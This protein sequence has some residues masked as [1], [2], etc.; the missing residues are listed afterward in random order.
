MSRL[1]AVYPEFGIQEFDD[2]AD[3]DRFSEDRESSAFGGADKRRVLKAC[4]HC[5]RHG[6]RAPMQR[7]GQF[8]PVAV[9]HDEVDDG[10]VKRLHIHEFERAI[11]GIRRLDGKAVSRKGACQHGGDF[12]II[13]DNQH[14]GDRLV[15]GFVGHFR[16]TRGN[17]ISCRRRQSPGISDNLY[18]A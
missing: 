17:I 10:R 7:G 18:R 2:L 11:A 13:V 12:R 15:Y 1:I 9:G 5:D 14:A 8:H 6:G 16:S 3:F 4:A